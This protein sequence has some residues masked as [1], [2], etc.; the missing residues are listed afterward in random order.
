MAYK[1]T[2]P[3]AGDTG[4]R[5]AISERT[6]AHTSIA[7]GNQ[8]PVKWRDVLPIHPAADFFPM[9]SPAELRELGE[10]IRKNGLKQRLVFWATEPGAEVFL[11]DGRNRRAAMVRSNCENFAV[12]FYA[13]IAR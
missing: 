4:A 8:A 11:L 10:D 13:H 9:M 7:E 2:S 5:Q 1:N 12:C 3:G 6:P